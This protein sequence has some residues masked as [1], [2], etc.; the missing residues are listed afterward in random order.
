[1]L[2]YELYVAEKMR[3]FEAERLRRVTLRYIA[4]ERRSLAVSAMTGLG[5]VLVRSGEF[6]AG[7]ATGDPVS[8]E[9]SLAKQ[10]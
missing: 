3:E 9:R 2:S 4:R 7:P 1:M 10:A 8:A 5:R 6:L